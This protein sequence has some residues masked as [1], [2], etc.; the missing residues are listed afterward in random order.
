M[1]NLSSYFYKPKKRDGE[2]ANKRRTL[3]HFPKII[4]KAVLKTCTVI[5]AMILLSALI[6]TILIFS[7]GGSGPKPLPNDI[8]LVFN[9]EEGIAELPTSPSF[10]DPFPF[11][12]PT[13]RGIVTAIYE[14]KE[15]NRVRGIVFRL[16]G[17]YLN[18]AHIQEIRTALVDF[19][20]SGKFTKIYA[21]SYIDV[22]GGLTQ[23]FL[24][25]AFDE[26]WMQPIG[27]MSISGPS[28]EMPFAR[29][30]LD[31]LGVKAEFFTREEFKSAMESFTNSDISES[32][33]DM[34]QSIVNDLSAQMMEKIAKERDM[35][36]SDLT[37]Q[38]DKG[39]LTGDEALNAK[40]L[41]RLEYP[42]VL[43]SEINQ[44]ITGDPNSEDLNLISF[45]RYT[46]E[47]KRAITQADVAL[48]YVAGTIVDDSE[49]Q[50]AA[51]GVE[52]AGFINDAAEDEEIEAII[53][54]VDS[55]GGS[56]SASESIRR[57]VVKAK[58]KGKKVVVSMGP[59]AA[60][61]GYWV[62]ANAD[63]IIANAGT[64]TGSIGVLMGKFEAST[65]WEKVGV[66]WQGPKMG[67][68]ADIW[69]MNQPFDARARERMTILIDETYDAFLSRVAEGRN[70]S[71]ESVRKVA[72][73]RVWTGEQAQEVGLV[74]VIGGLNTAKDETAKLI[75][76][77]NGTQI[78]L[79]RFPDDENRLE[80]LLALFGQQVGAQRFNVKETKLYREISPILTQ[81]NLLSHSP[82]AVYDPTVEAMR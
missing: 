41:D 20:Q 37:V 67:E 24:A 61:G 23:Y 76:L 25:S 7:A 31:K 8:V 60:S 49:S 28:F 78:N 58:E 82:I 26:I 34:L 55:P 27:M 16:N 53:L 56:P 81:A 13:V 45:K 50:G 5:G 77:E 64:L 73:G 11:I 52:V 1:K 10:V 14:A 54:R 35:A 22:G 69:S 62:A 63:K 70:M 79:V 36:L 59:T 18:V 4:W 17:A 72:K 42:D 48:I 75:G 39:L 19:K 44:E 43:K 15:D 74:D 21:P 29:N 2:I 6:S 46:Q 47:P 3:M 65:L 33:K 30:A 9:L 32:N 12:S 51:S 80:Q 40:L 68:N 66:N 38:V 71:K 57:A